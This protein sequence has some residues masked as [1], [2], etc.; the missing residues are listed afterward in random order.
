MLLRRDATGKFPEYP[1][2]DE[3]GSKAIFTEKDPAQ[4]IDLLLNYSSNNKVDKN[5]QP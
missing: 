1:T 4:V 2:Q 3:G 5:L